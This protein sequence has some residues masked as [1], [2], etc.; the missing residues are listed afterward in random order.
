[1]PLEQ[2]GGVVV[3]G[4]GRDVRFLLVT[5]KREPSRWVW[6]KGHIEAKESAEAAAV[7]EVREEAGV[8]ARVRAALGSVLVT[9][10]GTERRIE[11]F[12]MDYARDAS[13]QDD[14]GVEWCT[15]DVAWERLVFKESREIL[16]RAWKTLAAAR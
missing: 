5:A 1:V 15:Y 3:K 8:V 11:F 2:A 9:V 4:D 12:L 13:A 16:D 10:R 14:R 7:R 6:P